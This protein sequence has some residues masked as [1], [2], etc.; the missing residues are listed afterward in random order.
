MRILLEVVSHSDKIRG[1]IALEILLANPIACRSFQFLPLFPQ[2]MSHFFVFHNSQ[3]WFD[4]LVGPIPIHF[5]HIQFHIFG[6]IR[7][8]HYGGGQIWQLKFK[9]NVI[10]FVMSMTN[11]PFSSFSNPRLIF[12]MQSSKDQIRSFPLRVFSYPQL[13]SQQTKLCFVY[14]CQKTYLLSAKVFRV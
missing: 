7:P 11:G 9:R 3:I 14:A 2:C 1:H 5:R 12:R 10:E 8:I 6:P 13:F 4:D